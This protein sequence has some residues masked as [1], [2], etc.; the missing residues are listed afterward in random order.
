MTRAFWLS[1]LET[2]AREVSLTT[3]LQKALIRGG[4]STL[5]RLQTRVPNETA[6]VLTFFFSFFFFFFFFFGGDKQLLIGAVGPSVVRVTHKA[7][8]CFDHQKD[9]ECVKLEAL[10]T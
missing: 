10:P 3:E 2:K 6:I 1:S 9:M 7:K 8:S 4:F 5:Y